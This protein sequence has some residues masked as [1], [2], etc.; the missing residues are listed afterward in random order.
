MPQWEEVLPY[1]NAVHTDY[2]KNLDKMIECIAIKY[3]ISSERLCLGEE[4]R[5]PNMRQAKKFICK[6]CFEYFKVSITTKQINR[7]LN[8]RRKKF[9]YTAIV[10]IETVYNLLGDDRDRWVNGWREECSQYICRP[11]FED[12]NY[13]EFMLG[14]L[15]EYLSNHQNEYMSSHYSEIFDCFIRSRTA[16]GKKLGE[17]PVS[18]CLKNFSV[19][20]L[21]EEQ[22]P[23]FMYAYQG[24]QVYLKE[25]GE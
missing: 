9:P 2:S 17:I 19:E 1:R 4:V 10:I 22:I 7:L 18:E 8:P 5:T 12:M 16:Y 15:P 25:L 6:K 11:S 13:E 21:T 20:H 3:A 24:K 14:R 23:Q